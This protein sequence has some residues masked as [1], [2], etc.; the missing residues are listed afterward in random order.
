MPLTPT[1]LWNNAC[2]YDRLPSNSEVATFSDKNPW[3]KRTKRVVFPAGRSS[4]AKHKSKRTT[5][6]ASRVK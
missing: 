2:K 6:K 3:A 5:S 4:K 1:Q